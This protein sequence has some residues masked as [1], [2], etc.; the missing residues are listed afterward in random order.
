MN[1][2][3][4]VEDRKMSEEETQELFKRCCF[5]L[6]GMES[7]D[8]LFPMCLHLKFKKNKNPI[9]QNVRFQVGFK[10]GKITKSKALIYLKSQK[11]LKKHLYKRFSHIYLKPLLDTEYLDYFVLIYDIITNKIIR[12]MFY[13]LRRKF[14]ISEDPVS[15]ELGKNKFN[16]KTFLQNYNISYKQAKV[17]SGLFLEQV[18]NVCGEK[19][20]SRI[21]F[22]ETL[23]ILNNI[24]VE[25][26]YDK[27]SK[28]EIKESRCIKKSSVMEKLFL[29]EPNDCE[30][31]KLARAFVKNY[32]INLPLLYIFA[33]DIRCISDKLNSKDIVDQ[34]KAQS[35]KSEIYIKY[36]MLP[37]IYEEIIGGYIDFNG[38]GINYDLLL[39]NFK[40]I[41]CSHKSM[42]PYFLS[43][44]S[45]YEKTKMTDYGSALLLTE[46]P[47]DNIR[48]KE[49]L[50]KIIQY[51]KL[52]APNPLSE[53]I[54]IYKK[55]KNIRYYTEIYK[56]LM[57][58]AT[59]ER[60][61]DN[62]NKEK[63]QK[64]NVILLTI[65]F[66]LTFEETKKIMALT[67]YSFD[68]VG[69]DDNPEL[70][71]I[72]KYICKITKKRELTKADKNIIIQAIN[73]DMSYKELSEQLK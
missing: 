42:E 53:L 62:K 24:N 70:M 20:N 43:F 58:R 1:D 41:K 61:K 28:T 31:I 15:Y 55:K 34:F 64:L 36:C 16:Y 39:P 7:L 45:I 18:M 49:P 56:D 66:R 30:E 6:C 11:S 35:E 71:N 51:C 67:G 22:Y 48:I 9:W 59:F 52:A 25:S 50:D 57:S 26:A 46:L 17:N 72:L 23:N 69:V 65:G 5:V 27:G 14:G 33:N 44:K 32:N 37:L 60:M 19:I 68:K 21:G 3:E 2:I 63:P 29:T 73:L 4:N 13:Y 12:Q 8:V 47:F 40:E 10:W 54:K 38:E